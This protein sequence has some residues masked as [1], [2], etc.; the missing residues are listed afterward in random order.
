[1]KNTTLGGTPAY[2]DISVNTSVIDYDTAGTTVTGGKVIDFGS[3]GKSDSAGE[4][5]TPTTDIFLLPGETLTLAV[6]ATSGNTDTSVGIRWV[7]DF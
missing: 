1:V 7:E 4:S 3:L 6:R 2:T 5:G